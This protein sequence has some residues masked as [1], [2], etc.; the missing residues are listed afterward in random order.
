MSNNNFAVIMSAGK[1]HTV[2]PGSR[3]TVDR[4]NAEVGATI[5]LDNVLLAGYE[6]GTGV[7]VGSPKISGASVKA[8]VLSHDRGGKVIIF[9]KIRRTG[10]QKR[11][12]HRQEI[13]HLLVESVSC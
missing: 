9:K 3:L 5:T 10:Y 11:Q 12:G 4:V 2:K 13:T 8:K 1:Q 6:D 7:K